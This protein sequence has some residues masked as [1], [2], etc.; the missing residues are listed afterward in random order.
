MWEK[1]YHHYHDR[2]GME[3]PYT[4]QVLDK[5][6]PQKWYIKFPIGQSL[7]YQYLPV[8]PKGYVE[9]LGANKAH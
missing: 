2:M 5:I 7:M 8:Y 6:R 9:D 1:V 4:E 3:M